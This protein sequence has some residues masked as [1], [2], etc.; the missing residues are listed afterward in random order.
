MEQIQ[1]KPSLAKSSWRKH[2]WKILSGLVAAFFILLIVVNVIVPKI[3]SL[4]YP[5]CPQHFAGILTKPIIEPKDLDYI[6]PLGSLS[7][8]GHILPTNH[9]YLI[10]KDDET[11]PKRGKPLYAPGN[12][13]ITVIGDETQRYTGELA[14]SR[15]ESRF[16]HSIEI[17]VCR[18]VKMVIGG[19]TTLSDDIEK[20]KET[21]DKECFNFEGDKRLVDSKGIVAKDHCDYKL[22]YKIKAGEFLGYVR[23][24]EIGTFN[25]NK[26]LKYINP[27][28]YYAGDQMGDNLNGMCVFDLY[29]GSLKDSYYNLLGDPTFAGGKFRTIEPRCGELMQDKAGTLQGNWFDPKNKNGG[30]GDGRLVSLVHQNWD[31]T[32]GAISPGYAFMTDPIDA[33][34]ALTFYPTQSGTHNR[35]FSEVRPGGATYCYDEDKSL[36]W[37]DYPFKFLI[38]LLDDT[39]IKIEK[40]KGSCTTNEMFINP[41]TYER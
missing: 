10:V 3:D 26:P 18:G 13:T 24:F 34:H 11:Y 12:V 38:Q 23:S 6:I 9:V 41:F 25:T 37:S 16:D 17:Q 15:G 30:E 22:N 27:S 36:G 33:N 20:V 39:H 4:K 1:N 31:P 14:K 7:P 28:R 19:L 21:G 35:E 5:A 32:L 40:Q 29:S 2:W 8:P